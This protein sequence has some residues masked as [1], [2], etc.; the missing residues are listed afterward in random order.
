[1]LVGR[2]EGVEV[3]ENDTDDVRVCSIDRV[4]FDEC[5]ND[6]ELLVVADIL[7]DFL[8]VAEPLADLDSDAIDEKVG[9]ELDKE[10]SVGLAV[11]VLLSVDVLVTDTVGLLVCV[12][13]TE[14]EI[15]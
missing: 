12:C 3:S 13:L 9:L 2:E 11:D 10:E 4:I 6:D 7:T 1:M 15:V 5:V 8:G 14:K